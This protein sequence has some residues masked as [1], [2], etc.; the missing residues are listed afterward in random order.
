MIGRRTTYPLRR[1]PIR[2]RLQFVA[3]LPR[4]FQT[5]THYLAGMMKNI[6]QKRSRP[7]LFIYL[8]IFITPDG[9]QI[10]SAQL[11]LAAEC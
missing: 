8:F 5:T 4:A 6:I 11:L 9:S 7:I 3:H 1:Y 10:Y 2:A